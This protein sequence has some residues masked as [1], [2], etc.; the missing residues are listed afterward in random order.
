MHIPVRAK[1]Y[2]SLLALVPQ[3]PNLGRLCWRLW[4]DRRVPRYLKLMVVAVLLYVFSP[5]DLVPGFLAPVIGQLD[6]A[7][8]ALLAGYLLIR[9]S[10]REVVD[11]HLSALR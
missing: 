2:R 10:P 4:R 7:T 5:L 11:E 3:L 8:L 6:D 1:N 9:L